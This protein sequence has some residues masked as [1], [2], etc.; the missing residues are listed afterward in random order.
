MF[1]AANKRSVLD[2]RL[3]AL[4][5]VYASDDLDPDL[6]EEIEA[7]ERNFLEFVKEAWPS[8]DNTPFCSSWAI[9]ALCDHLQ[10]VTEGQI[11]RLLVNFPP[12]CGKPVRISEL[13]NTRR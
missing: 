4:E 2:R 9:E 11:D 7:L 13:V 5:A 12:R 3:A 8:I 1:T 10:A 6:A